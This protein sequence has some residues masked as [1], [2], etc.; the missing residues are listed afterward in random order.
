MPYV[1]SETLP[2][3]ACA[4]KTTRDAAVV[5][6]VAKDSF[7][8]MPTMERYFVEFAEKDGYNAYFQD[9]FAFTP[10]FS[11]LPAPEV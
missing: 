5:R 6:D 8:L 1:D 4:G 7:S 9:L 2:A 10:L 3:L 11:C